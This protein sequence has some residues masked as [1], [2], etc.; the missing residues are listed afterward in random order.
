MKQIKKD[1]YQ[2]HY[3]KWWWGETAHIVSNDGKGIVRV[4]FEY[5]YSY[6]FI[7]D[8]SVVEDA[9]RKGYATGILDVAHDLIKKNG[10]RWAILTCE[11]ERVFQRAFYER[12]G[13]KVTGERKHDY[14]MR[15]DL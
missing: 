4:E 14:L 8:L 2:I 7:T 11:F 12:I 6:G 1:G 10:Y 15:K 9:R 3:N 5:G 13:Y